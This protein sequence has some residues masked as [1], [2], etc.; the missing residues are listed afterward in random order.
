MAAEALFTCPDDL[1]LIGDGE[2]ADLST[3]AHAE[4][5]RVSGLDDLS[6][7]TLTYAAALADH[8]DR[9]KVETGARAERARLSAAQ[10]QDAAS[11]EMARLAERVNGPAGSTPAVEQVTTEG[12]AAA[13]AAAMAGVFAGNGNTPADVVKRA[14]SLGATRQHAPAPGVLPKAMLKVTSARDLPS[15][16]LSAGADVPSMAAMADAF[17][18]AARGIPATA[19]GKAAPRHMVASVKNEFAHTVDDRTNPM[20]VQRLHREMTGGDKPEALLAAGGWCAPSEIKY[21]LFNI[22]EPPV[23][24]IDLPTV[25]ISRGGLQYPVSPAIGDV[26]FTSGASNAASGM[27]SFAFTFSNASDPWLWTEA[28]DI[29][30]VTGSVNKPTL[31][32][33]CAS[34]STT[35]LEAYGITLTAGNLTNN[36][37]PEQTENFLRLLRTAYAHAI[38]ARLISLMVTA[39]GGANTVGAITTDPAAP[40]LMNAVAM[41]ATDYR[42]RYAMRNDAVLE[43]IYPY[44]VKEVLRADIAY[45]VGLDSPELFAVADNIIDTFFTARGVHV[46]WVDDWQVR[47]ASQPGNATVQLVW[48]ATVQFMIYAAGTFLHGTGLTLDLGV[49]RD[50]VLNAENDYT[51]AW[52]EEAHLI[53]QVGHASRLYTCAFQVNGA[54]GSG[55]TARV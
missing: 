32:V 40:R 14:A 31:R 38:N 4:F 54:S 44:W 55:T 17:I 20:D 10:N 16:Q 25:G 3:Q 35:R 45:K 8:L 27:G 2:L 30:T 26:F 41:A 21:D 34:F 6:P 7:E 18:D 5:E 28:D 42:A 37:Y 43:V 24:V 1:T 50:S 12:I 15:R 39:S 52:A 19:V 49:V 11:R 53:A 33:P 13:V 46:Q 23:G 22:A 29:A 36:A 47:G 51:A 9:L 48:P